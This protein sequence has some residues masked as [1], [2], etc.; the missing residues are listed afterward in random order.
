MSDGLI[1]R[2]QCAA[3]KI[4]RTRFFSAVYLHAQVE[5]LVQCH[6][7]HRAPPQSA[8]SCQYCCP[9]EYISP[10]TAQHLSASQHL[11]SCD[12]DCVDRLEGGILTF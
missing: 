11:R 6:F 2:D 7:L 4:A 8:D 9:F 1:H 10:Y 12:G 3:M 5:K